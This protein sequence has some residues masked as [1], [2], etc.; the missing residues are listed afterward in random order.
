LLPFSDSPNNA[1]GIGLTEGDIPWCGSR[2]RA[3]HYR[4]VEL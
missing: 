2:V 3:T 4:G 1:N